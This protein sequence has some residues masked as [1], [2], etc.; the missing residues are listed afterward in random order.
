MPKATITA[1]ALLSLAAVAILGLI[2]YGLPGPAPEPQ[3]LTA[4]TQEL[5]TAAALSTLAD[6]VSAL[7]RREKGKATIEY[8]EETANTARAL[9]TDV[10]RLAA[11]VSELRALAH[12][13]AGQHAAPAKKTLTTGAIKK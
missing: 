7:E 4:P 3:R 2:T 12:P 10:D 8:A 9:R 5:A 11:D 6:R 1:G 13:P